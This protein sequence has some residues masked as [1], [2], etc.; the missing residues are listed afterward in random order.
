MNHLDDDE[1]EGLKDN[2]AT[3]LLYRM[4]RFGNK[5]REFENMTEIGENPRIGVNYQRTREM[6]DVPLLC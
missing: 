4:R 6:R 5:V 2:P 1:L 3:C